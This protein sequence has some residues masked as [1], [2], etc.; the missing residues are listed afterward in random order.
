MLSFLLGCVEGPRQRI[1]TPPESDAQPEPAPVET[2]P[3]V[4]ADPLGTRPP[5]GVDVLDLDTGA[6]VTIGGADRF[7]VPEGLLRVGFLAPLSGPR[8]AIGEALLNA[9]QMALFDAGEDRVSLLPLDTAG[10]PARARA[11]FQAAI[12][13]GASLILGP[14]FAD[15]VQAIAPFA[16]SANVPVIAFSNNR[17][18]SAPGVYLLGVTPA[19]QVDRIL[20]YA[21][22]RGYVRFAALVPDNAYGEIVASAVAHNARRLG[23]A[24]ERIEYFGQDRRALNQL[25]ERIAKD[26]AAA[27]KA[28]APTF[29]AVLIAGG[30]Q[31]LRSVA[32]LFPYHDV[33]INEVR[34]L[35]LETWHRDSNLGEPALIGG[36]FASLPATQWRPFVDRYRQL[37]GTAPPRPAALAYDAVTMVATALGGQLSPRIS[38]ARL[39]DPNGFNGVQGAFRLDPDGIARRGLAVYVVRS[40][41]FRVIDPA[42]DLFD[43]PS[44]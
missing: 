3:D 1:V 39:E 28:L 8:A 20:T 7:G 19:Q 16:R 18:V 26:R 6:P 14:L 22:D 11:A 34:L 30:G 42:P 38:R 36:W 9:A 31:D 27:M 15:S 10:E 12:D 4:V 40:K 32:P 21:A 41:D 43:T 13:Q 2:E 37:F 35:G 5:A 29:D 24:I 33:D 23:T 44:F 25:V 17:A